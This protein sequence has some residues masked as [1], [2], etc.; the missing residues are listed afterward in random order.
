MIISRF[1]GRFA[2]TAMLVASMAVALSEMPTPAAAATPAPPSGACTLKTPS[3]LGYTMLIAGAGAT[4]VDADKVAIAYKGTLAA[5]GT[6]FDQSERAEF[7]VRDVIPGFTEGLKLLKVGGRIRLCIPARLGYGGQA[8]GT[9]P[10][11]SDLVFEIG[12][13]DIKKAPGPLAAAD[14]Q[15]ASKSASG[16]GYTVVKAGSGAQPTDSDVTLVNY[17]GYVAATGAPFD[18][19]GPVPIPVSRVIPG[20]AEGLKLMQRGAS[21]KLCIPATLGYGDKE[22]GPI[23]ANSALIFL[24]DLI[25]FKS[26]AE[27]QAM[28]GQPQQ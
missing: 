3:G 15:C 5:D 4:P 23:P 25:D 24:I 10:A 20:F 19:A 18:D 9:I 16:L 13:L 21:Y 28:Q 8:A 1:P 17:K 12:L 22:T 7:G 2:R 11:N 14:R 27:I 26:I 6:Q